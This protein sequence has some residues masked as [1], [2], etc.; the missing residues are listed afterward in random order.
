MIVEL[1]VVLHF[2]HNVVKVYI[3]HNYR[4]TQYDKYI[5]TTSAVLWKCEKFHKA[6]PPKQKLSTN[7]NL[8]TFIHVLHQE[9]NVEL[10]FQR[11]DRLWKYMR[12]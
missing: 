4:S 5:H 10:W 6:T 12:A 1:P 11:V 2:L 7:G 8:G 3:G 9:H